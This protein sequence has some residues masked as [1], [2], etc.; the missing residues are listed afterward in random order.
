M[1]FDGIELVNQIPFRPTV[2]LND[3]ETSCAGSLIFISL[4]FIF[5]QTTLICKL[6]FDSNTKIIVLT[7][8][9]PIRDSMT[10]ITG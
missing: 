3:F 1:I 4:K 10:A 5:N 6:I 7:N 2:S 9:K 8:Y